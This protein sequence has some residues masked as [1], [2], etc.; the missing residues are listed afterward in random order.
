MRKPKEKVQTCNHLVSEEVALKLGLHPI[1]DIALIDEVVSAQ[2]D[3][4]VERIR[5]GSF[6]GVLWPLMGKFQV[7]KENV[8][9][10]HHRREANDIRKNTTK[11]K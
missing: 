1:K 3:F 5:E 11:P 8:H 2:V 4:T 6:D 7:K 9:L 10:S